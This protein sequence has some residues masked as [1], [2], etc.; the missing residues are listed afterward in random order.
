[1]AATTPSRNRR[2]SS[3]GMH[4]QAVLLLFGISMA[5]AVMLSCTGLFL[6]VCFRSIIS[7]MGIL[8]GFLF[9]SSV[10]NIPGQFRVLSQIWSHCPAKLISVTGGLMDHRPVP[11]F[12]TYLTSY[13]AGPF[14]YLILSLLSVL[15]GYFVW[16]RWQA[17]GR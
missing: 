15:G 3:K 1:M 12:G 6:S 2:L 17:G 7:A 11:F 4:R 9:I 13:Q 16:R 10:L 14:I 5:A 8:I